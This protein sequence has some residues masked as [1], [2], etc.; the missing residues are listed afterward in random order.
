VQQ[1]GFLVKRRHVYYQV[2]KPEHATWAVFSGETGSHGSGQPF[3]WSVNSIVGGK[4]VEKLP[5]HCHICKIEFAIELGKGGIC[6]NCN[7]PTC[8]RHFASTHEVEGKKVFICSECFAK[9]PNT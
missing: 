3:R 7:K 4:M 1:D 8:N 9:S 6:D 2:N 5:W